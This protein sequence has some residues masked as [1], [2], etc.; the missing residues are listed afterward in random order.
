MAYACGLLHAMLL[1][2]GPAQHQQ[3]AAPAAAA[4]ASLLVPDKRLQLA[5]SAPPRERV[6]FDFGWRHMLLRGAPPPS[7]PPPPAMGPPDCLEPWPANASGIECSGGVPHQVPDISAEICASA[8]CSDSLCAHWQFN[9]NGSDPKGGTIHETRRCMLSPTPPGPGCTNGTP[10]VVGGSRPAREPPPPGPSPPSPSPSDH[11][12]QAQPSYDDSGWQVVNV[13]HDMNVDQAPERIACEYGC[14]GRSFLARHSGWYR[15][16]FRVPA[17]WAGE[18][19]SVEFEG[20]FRHAMVY[21]NGRILQNHTSGYTSFDVALPTATLKSG[22]HVNVLAVYADARSGTG[23]WYE[24]GGIYRHVWLV[25]RSQTHLTTWGTFVAPHVHPLS[26]V[27][28]T[29]SGS[30]R[31]AATLNVS[32]QLSSQNAASVSLTCD[33]LDVSGKLLTT[34]SS[35]S[36]MRVAADGLLVLHASVDVP[37]VRLWTLRAPILYRV[38]TRLLTSSKTVLDEENTTIGFRSLKYT[39]DSGFFLNEEHYKVRGFCDHNNFASVGMAVPDRVNL[40]RANAARSIGGNGRRMS[41][42]PGAPAMFDIYDRVGMVVMDENREFQ[43]GAQ[44]NRELADMVGRD[45]NHPSITIWSFCNEQGCGAAPTDPVQEAGVA[46]R[47]L[48]DELDGTRPTLGNMRSNDWGGLLTNETDVEGFSHSGRQGID[49]FRARFPDKP[50]FES[51]CCSCNTQRGENSCKGAGCDGSTD[52]RSGVQSSFN[53]DCLAEQTNASQGV[54]YVVG[55]MVWTLF[56]CE[57]QQQ[58]FESSRGTHRSSGKD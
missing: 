26:I 36:D 49:Q 40:F 5:A 42:N 20:V 8:C 16:H 27:A 15:K 46:F 51:E 39:A 3:P 25:K 57:S 53:A 44:Y 21:L 52:R 56:D 10:G 12:E 17:D 9:I 7:Y 41:H 58:L 4:S 35:P 13:P 23:W 29:N 28:D 19:I 33:L 37:A 48:T 55:D 11:P 2:T 14:G 45:R 18:H 38:R 50:L 31:A 54:P 6:K 22:S 1:L 32:A 43:V 24:G 34:F 47:A 30:L